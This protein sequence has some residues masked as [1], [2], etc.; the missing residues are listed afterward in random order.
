M[1]FLS[2]IRRWALRDKMPIREISRRTGLSRNTIRKYLREGAV[3]PKFKTPARP[4][5]LDPYADRLSA[6]LLAQ[7][8]KSRKERRTVK[9]PL[10]TFF[11]ENALSVS[12][13]MRIWPSS[14]T[15]GPTDVWQLLPGH[16]G[17]IGFAQSRQQDAAP[18]S[19]WCFNPARHSSSI[20]A[21]IG[22]V[23]AANGSSFRWRIRS[24]RTA[25]PSWYGLIRFRRTRCYS[26]PIGT[27]SASLV[28]CR[29]GVSTTT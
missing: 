23:S 11:C 9:Q 6:W 21:R 19:P 14:A 4:S 22:P 10:V 27:P 3:E 8:H 13:Y 25:A 28:A 5:K 1:E 26:M 16:G 17:R 24:C 2:V 18:S 12:G 29:G 15:M 7:T 20:G